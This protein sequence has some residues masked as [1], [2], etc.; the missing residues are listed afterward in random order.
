MHVAIY[1]AFIRFFFS[2]NRIYVYLFV[3]NEE[4]EFCLDEFGSV[5]RSTH[6]S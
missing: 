6:E 2:L 3:W 1:S 5:L 4:R